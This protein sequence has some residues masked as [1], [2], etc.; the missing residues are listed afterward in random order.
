MQETA[1]IISTTR[2]EEALERCAL[3][4]RLEDMGNYEASRRALG[5][6]WQLVGDR[7]RLDHLD[8]KVCAEVMLRAGT[9]TGWLGS[10]NQI[11]RAQEAAKDLLS[12]SAGI[13]ETLRLDLKVQEAHIEL[14]YCYWRQGAYDEARVLLQDAVDRIGDRDVELKAKGTLRRIIVERTS[15]GCAVAFPM[16]TE[17]STLFQQISH[18]TVKGGYHVELAVA[19][20]NLGHAEKR[21]EYIDRA[22]VE[23]EAA[24]Y[25]F[26]QA[27][28]SRYRA[29]VENNLGNL[30]YELSRFDQA[31]K[32]LDRAKR[33]FTSLR[34]KVHGALTDETR[35]SVLLAQGRNSEA[36]RVARCAVNALDGGEEQALLCQVLTTHA[37]SI[38]RLKRFPQAHLTLRRAVEL[39]EEVGDHEGAGRATITMI[40]ELGE[41]LNAGELQ[42]SY[43][44][45]ESF[46]SKSCDPV[47]LSRLRRCAIRV[48]QGQRV[49]SSGDGGATDRRGNPSPQFIHNSE[50]TRKLLEY[51]QRVAATDRTA[52]ISGE[53]GTGKEIMAKL[54]HAWSGRPGKFVALN[55]AALTETLFE[56]EL[57]GHKRG[58][59]TDAV[60]DRLG[61]AREA[62][63]G[64]L[65]L[66]EVAELSPRNQAKLLRLVES[67]EVLTVGAAAPER[68]NVRILAATNR[69]LR[70]MTEDKSFRLDLYFRLTTHVIQIPA[71]RDRREDIPAIARHLIDECTRRYGKQVTWSPASIAALQHLHLS[72][73][74]R[75]MRS[76][77]ER[78]TLLAAQNQTI[79]PQAVAT[80][81]LRQSS[82]E[83]DLANE[84]RGCVLGE[85][86]RRYEGELIEQALI[87]SGGQI[88]RAARLLGVS[89]QS[90][91]LMLDGRHQ[92]LRTARNLA[93][94]R[95]SILPK[96]L[97]TPVSITQSK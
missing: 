28:H 86:V 21:P 44:L 55:C 39:A 47:T 31:D 93:K 62:N 66:D 69:D 73:N 92:K 77:I 76:L 20:K 19:L 79:T 42:K 90:L 13:F 38:A 49:S 87:A 63:A 14:G 43:E 15:A 45:A 41:A 9:L 94:R 82:N 71:L 29:S 18:H 10:V 54:I 1:Q 53:T 84:W 88:T 32:H 5:E 89:H 22:L 11:E 64:T 33:L 57:F 83:G 16:L 61:A 8:E 65:F 37:V 51:A 7:P 85:E 26:E 27:G 68:V 12:E 46:L 2:S 52:L 67:G 56:T 91:S 35:A 97:R 24:S 34:D 81:N 48:I 58:S 17:S 50:G 25:H 75:E 3:A 78:T 96:T 95:K 36:E 40:E 72:G 60:E 59:F 4:K 30:F 70:Q 80:M 6:L 23:Y 74:A